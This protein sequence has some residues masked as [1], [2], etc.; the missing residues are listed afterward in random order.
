MQRAWEEAHREETERKKKEERE[1]R[2][3]TIAP[4]LPLLQ[5]SGSASSWL[6]A[7]MGLEGCRGAEEKNVY[8]YTLLNIHIRDMNKNFFLFFSRHLVLLLHF[9]TGILRVPHWYFEGSTLVKS[10][11]WCVCGIM[12]IVL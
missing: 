4:Y 12:E 8:L 11:R 2:V 9:L 6:M 1:G 7:G 3:D 10:H 5:V